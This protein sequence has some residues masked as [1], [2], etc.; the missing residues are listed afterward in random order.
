MN[1]GS[2]GWN[3]RQAVSAAA[4]LAVG[5]AF[6]S[7]TWGQSANSRSGTARLDGID[8]YYEVHGGTT[9]G[10][11]VP[12]VLLH[13]GAVTIESAFTPELIGRFAARQP[14][15][16]IEQQGHGHTA[17]RPGK[18]ITI[19]QMVKDTAGVLAHLNV[20]QADLF[21]HSLGGIVA[22]GVAIRHADI[23]RKVTT[24]GTPYQLD[25]FRPDLARMQR[26]STEA[27]SPE[28]VQ[29]LPTEADFAAWRAS[30]E[31]SAPDP[32]A[33]DSILGR[34]NTM[35][36]TWPGWAEGELRSILAPMLIAIGDND[37][38]RIDHAA[39]FARLVPNARL[40]VL[41]GTT[42]LHIVKRDAW[43]APM[44]DALME[45]RQ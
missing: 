27:P 21:G 8:V 45:P 10:A 25:G 12:I 43:L 1:T 37:Y 33:F 34:L 41:P 6:S 17:D 28:L 19:D 20:P 24:L 42:H 14:V 32:T 3:R 26:G 39:E 15:I 44:I 22:T 36:A 18:P 11:T 31:R 40:A 2:I 38:V 4:F 5:S 7:R 29:L 13:G 35:L 30:F 9:D 16:A 23:V